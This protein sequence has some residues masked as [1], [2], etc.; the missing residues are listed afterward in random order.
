MGASV[1]A[2]PVPA[3]RKRC[4]FPFGVAGIR[5]YLRAQGC[6]G[7]PVGDL[8]E[9]ASSFPSMG[10][11]MNGPLLRGLAA[12]VPDGMAIVELGTWLGAGTAQLAIGVSDRPVPVTIHSYDEFRVNR[13][14]YAWAGIH[15]PELGL[16]LGQDTRAM[17]AAALAPFGQ[18][19]RLHA[20]SILEK[21]W[22]G[23]PIGLFVDDLT[24]TPIPFHHALVTFGPSWVPGVTALVLMDYFYWK[25][26]ERWRRDTLRVQTIFIEAHASHFEPIDF[27]YAP[28]PSTRAFLYTRELDFARLPP[29]KVRRTLDGR[30]AGAM[31]RVRRLLGWA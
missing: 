25:K 18:D 9:H 3:V 16:G 12:K 7:V 19:V 14:D 22:T 23:G 8:L 30:A 17:V 21:R 6:K 20:G 13:T 26:A 1:L 28:I 2:S 31:R 27:D 11:T 15:H 29:F 5:E 10:G 4:H 24:K